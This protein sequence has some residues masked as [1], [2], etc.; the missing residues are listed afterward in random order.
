MQNI[1]PYWL[2]GGAALLLVVNVLPMYYLVRINASAFR[3]IRRGVVMSPLWMGFVCLVI[4][5]GN[6]AAITP[7]AVAATLATAFFVYY[8]IPRLVQKK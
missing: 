1:S 5:V 3:S 7:P 2:W 6:L 8:L 4:G